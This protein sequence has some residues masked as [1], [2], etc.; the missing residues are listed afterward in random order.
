MKAAKKCKILALEP[1]RARQEVKVNFKDEHR[2]RKAII[3][4]DMDAFYPSV[5]VLD[6]PSLRGK[7]VIVG[8][9]RERGVV[10]SDEA[11]LDV[12]GTQRL[13]GEPAGVAA[14]IKKAVFGE[15][16]LTVSAGVAPNKFVSKIASDI[17]KPDGLTIVSPDAM[18][19]FLDPLPIG[20]MWGVGRKT[21]Q[22]LIE[23]KMLTFRDFR[24]MSAHILEK[25]TG[26]S[27]RQDATPG[28]RHRRERGRYRAGGK[29]NR[30]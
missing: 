10:S 16:G 6:D 17:A 18:T 13:L 7:P 3:H 26:R 19:E 25:K 12:T 2:C 22:V 8:G 4:L 28:L 5:E 20:K 14:M 11:F 29:I 24:L 15:T 9:S 30:P 23:M 21:E 27:W 1:C